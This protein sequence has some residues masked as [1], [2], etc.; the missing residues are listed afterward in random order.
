MLRYVADI[1]NVDLMLR[2]QSEN[3]DL[4]NYS[5]SDFVDLKNKRHSIDEYVFMLVDE[6]ISHLSKQQQTIALSSCEVKYMTLSKAAK[7]AI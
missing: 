7:E 5:D 6:T 1:T 3:N 2:K 4:I